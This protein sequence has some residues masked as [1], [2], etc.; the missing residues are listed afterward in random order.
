MFR[1]SS[2]IIQKFDVKLAEMNARKSCRVNRST[3]EAEIDPNLNY[4]LLNENNVSNG[5]ND[6]QARA[7]M[8]SFENQN[9][10]YQYKRCYP[11]RHQKCVNI[12]CGVSTSHRFI[13]ITDRNDPTRVKPI[14]CFECKTH[15]Q[16]HKSFPVKSDPKRCMAENCSRKSSTFSNV[17]DENG[18][19]VG[20]LCAP[21]SNKPNAYH[22]PDMSNWKCENPFCNLPYVED[23]KIHRTNR[24]FDIVCTKP[25]TKLCNKMS[26]LCKSS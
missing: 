16:I 5:L 26:L 25:I 7:L 2:S 10:D 15:H 4:V 6:E 1:P 19:L 17:E 12:A 13:A 11:L 18:N 3:V 9:G 20:Y 23:R 22:H 21:C 24:I 8:E 14:C